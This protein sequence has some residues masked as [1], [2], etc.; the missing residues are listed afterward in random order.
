MGKIDTKKALL[1]LLSLPGKSGHINE[2]I[3]GVTRVQKMIFLFE[4]ELVPN[5]RKIEKFEYSDSGFMAYK[6]G[7]YSNDVS[8]SL[9]FFIA[10][11]FI[12]EKELQ[13]KKPVSDI[14]EEKEFDNDIEFYYN[15]NDNYD[16][17]L[18]EYFLSKKGMRFVEQKL[19]S[20]FTFEQR[21]ALIEFKVRINSLPLNAILHYVYSSYPDMTE[22]STIKDKV[23]K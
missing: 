12:V 8:D 20:M 22:K 4:K 17:R 23:L 21:E 3:E 13:T 5:L 7:P 9:R 15:E 16:G 14:E 10:A 11:D 2:P 19:D 1:Y 6:F 18:T